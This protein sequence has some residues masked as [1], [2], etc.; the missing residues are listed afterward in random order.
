MPAHW[1]AEAR[2]IV[3]DPDAAAAH[4]LAAALAWRI[5]R[6]LPPLVCIKGGKP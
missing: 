1:L 4:P 6:G 5:L 3:T 2:R